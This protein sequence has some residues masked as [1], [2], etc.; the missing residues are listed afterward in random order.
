MNLILLTPADFISEKVVRLSG[1]RFEHICQYH[2]PEIGKELRAGIVDGNVGKATIESID[3]RSITLRVNCLDAPPPQLPVTLVMALPRPKVLRRVLQTVATF[4]V[5]EVIFINSYKVEKS[6]WQ[7]PLLTEQ[8]R[9][10]NFTLGLEQA[11]ATQPPK[12]Q[13]EKRFKPFVEDT[14][15]L[16]AQEHQRA[17][18]AHPY[19]AQS[20]PRVSQEKTL[21]AI[22]PEG[23]FIPYEV[24][25]LQEAGLKSFDLGP[26]ILRVETALS[27]ILGRLF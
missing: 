8:K 2:H 26:R 22:G 4:G 18:V 5:E 11:V 23:G 15:P 25:K 19:H 13:L 3:S 20:T 7:T 12:V 27:V 14:L 21:L 1:R 6:F 10:E 9:A 24:E 16:L 17:L